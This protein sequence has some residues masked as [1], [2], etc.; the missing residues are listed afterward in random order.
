MSVPTIGQKSQMN[1]IHKVKTGGT[2][3]SL[4]LSRS[5]YQNMYMK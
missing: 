2:P 1:G 4:Q 3:C 5:K